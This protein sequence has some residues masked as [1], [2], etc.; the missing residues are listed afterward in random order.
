MKK[1]ISIEIKWDDGSMSIAEGES[2]TRIMEW[3]GA[4][5]TMN[6]IHGAVYSGPH[7]QVTEAAHK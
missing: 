7:F 6:L 1:A 3:Y 4:C 2:A 5:E